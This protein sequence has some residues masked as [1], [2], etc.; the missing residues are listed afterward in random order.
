MRRNILL[1]VTGLLIPFIYIKY[2]M[3]GLRLTFKELYSILL[4][5]H[6]SGEPYGETDA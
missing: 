5:H 1:I 4:E 3:Y 6:K 2:S